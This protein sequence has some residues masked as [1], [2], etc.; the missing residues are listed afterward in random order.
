MSFIAHDDFHTYAFG[1]FSLDTAR[2]ALLKNGVEIKLRPQSFEILRV[3]TSR[4]GILVTREELQ[5]AR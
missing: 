2:G 1:V 4:S 3:L 5:T